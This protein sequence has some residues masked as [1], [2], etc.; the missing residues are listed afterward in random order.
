MHT[1]PCNDIYKDSIVKISYSSISLN[2]S[3]A[4]IKNL[5]KFYIYLANK[6]NLLSNSS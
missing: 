2:I 6:E 4:E 3:N 5:E 1:N